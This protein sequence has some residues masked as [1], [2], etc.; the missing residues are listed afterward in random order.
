[1]TYEPGVTVIAQGRKRVDLGGTTFMYG[2]GQYLL[3]S[4]RFTNR[5]PDRRGQCSS[6]LSRDVSEARNARNS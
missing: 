3:T 6:P 1:M 4:D 2:E 5:R